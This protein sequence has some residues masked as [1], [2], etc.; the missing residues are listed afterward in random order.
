M[1]TIRDGQTVTQALNERTR[2]N[3]KPGRK[4]TMTDEQEDELVR[5]YLSTEEPLR[6]VAASMGISRATAT[7]ALRRARE[8]LKDV[9]ALSFME[10][11]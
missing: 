6:D 2:V 11:K 5:R 7:R 3:R 1:V 9:I 4:P 10:P 8:R